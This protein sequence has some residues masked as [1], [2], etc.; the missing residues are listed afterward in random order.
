MIDNYYSNHIMMKKKETGQNVFKLGLDIFIPY[1]CRSGDEGTYPDLID[2][3][4]K[5]LSTIHPKRYASPIKM[6]WP[7]VL[8]HRIL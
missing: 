5:R 2:F 6:T 4:E 8:V 7:A 3:T 1:S